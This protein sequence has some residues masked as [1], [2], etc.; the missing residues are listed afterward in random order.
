M[1]RFI[2]VFDS[3]MGGVT[4][5]SDLAKELPHENF[6]FYGDSINAPYGVRDKNIIIDLTDSA[7]EKLVNRGAK[8][9]VIACNTATSAAIDYLRNKYDV[10]IVGM[11]PAVKPALEGNMGGKVVVM[12]TPMTLKLDKFNLLVDRLKGNDKVIKAPS[13][14]L[15][16]FVEN[17]DTE[18]I[19][20]ES[21]IKE[22]FKEYGIGEIESIVLGCTHFLYLRK[23]LKNM[24]GKNIKIY[25]G[26]MGTV[27]RVKQ[28]LKDT[29]LFKNDQMKGYIK[30]ENS[31]S[32]EMVK[33]SFELFNRY[34][35][36]ER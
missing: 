30:I 4:V 31:L 21:Y 1:E 24:F 15:V 26:N 9:I 33:Q 22:T 35:E 3:G 2:G 25:D 19:E 28:I 32:D 20:I 10:P 8:L 5:L 12:A 34:Q 23:V 27:R 11:E 36:I 16:E 17:G 7:I 18:G 6:I 13:P 29:D 14:K